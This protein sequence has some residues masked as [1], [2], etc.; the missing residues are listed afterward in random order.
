MQ[1]SAITTVIRNVKW[2]NVTAQGEAAG[3]IEYA[4]DWTMTNVKLQT[5]DGLPV[6]TSNNRKVDTPHVVKQ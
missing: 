6:R 4:R 3:I 5:R 2:I 1:T